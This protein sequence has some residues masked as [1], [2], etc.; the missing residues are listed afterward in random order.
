MLHAI[1]PM[2]WQALQT[3]KEPNENAVKRSKLQVLSHNLSAD[4]TLSELLKIFDTS[5]PKELDTVE[6]RLYLDSV[7]HEAVQTLVKEKSVK[8]QKICVERVH[9]VCWVLCRA[10][11]K[12]QHTSMMT[13]ECTKIWWKIFTTFAER[14]H[15]N[16]R[17][18]YPVVMDWEEVDYWA[19]VVL[20]VMALPTN[21]PS[22]KEKEVMGSTALNFQEALV[23]FN[24]KLNE[25]NGM[26][27]L[28]GEGNPDLKYVE[29]AMQ[30]LNIR[31]FE[32][33][34][35]NGF[36]LP[37]K[38]NHTQHPKWCVL[39]Q[40][41]MAFADNPAEVDSNNLR[42]FIPIGEC[43]EVTPIYD[44]NN[45]PVRFQLKNGKDAKEPMVFEANNISIRNKWV[46]AIICLKHRKLPD[47]EKDFVSRRKAR[48]RNRQ[49]E[50][51]AKET[52]RQQKE[53]TKKQVEDMD[54]AMKAE[55]E[56]H[57]L[58]A[59]QMRSAT[60]EQLKEIIDQHDCR[61]AAL[62][63]QM[64]DLGVQY[65]AERTLLVEQH[66]REV[67]QLAQQH[68]DQLGNVQTELESEIARLKAMLEAERETHKAEL[69]ERDARI[70]ELE[71]EI[72]RLKDL[73]DSRAKETEEAAARLT[74]EVAELRR[75][76]NESMEQSREDRSAID[77]L[78]EENEELKAKTERFEA[79][80]RQ[81]IAK[82][83]S[84]VPSA[85]YEEDELLHD[86]IFRETGFSRQDKVA[87]ENVNDFNIQTARKADATD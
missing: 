25:N 77:K 16:E 21:T 7:I 86:A 75:Q 44:K 2:I 79:Q 61:M 43:T 55:Q 69:S 15:Q 74:G 12:D 33:I 18:L 59:D 49:L 17:T 32:G 50:V 22:R 24:A 19:N 30:E 29:N 34:H 37:V 45:R 39:Y 80:I 72:Q 11:V 3:L 35:L 53:R 76:L 41:G 20:K 60:A 52:M 5:A 51:E 23:R 83:R 67:Q 47:Y 13:D 8:Q 82:Q 64:T 46:T 62:M 6:C 27:V 87:S 31:L 1:K 68:G 40:L 84:V 42:A 9:E 54:R 73:L 70:A 57:Q 26:Y 56:K 38:K 85:I 66:E 48:V 81:G 4:G 10:Q 65:E 71:K 14:D 58:E 36:L 28:D 78:T 63:R